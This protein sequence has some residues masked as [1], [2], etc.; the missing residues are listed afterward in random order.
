M[1]WNIFQWRSLKTRVTLFTLAIFLIGIWALALYASRML[2]EDM[3]RLLGEQ[4]F[5]VVSFMATEINHELD[6]RLRALETIA[7]SVSPAL[8][9]NMAALQVLLEQRPV[10]QSLFNGGVTALGLDGTAI[11]DVPLSAGRIGV[12]Y[13]DVDVTASALRE[14]KSTISRPIMGKKLRAPVFVMAVPIRDTR[15]KVIGALAGVTDLGKPNFLDKITENSYGKT[16]GYLLVAQQHRLI[17]TATDKSRIMEAL[18]APGTN[19]SMDRFMQG[20]EGYALMLNP[21][22]VEMLAAAKGVPVAGWYVVAVLHTAEAF[23]PIRALQQRMLLA[24]IFL[25]LLAGVLIWWML[26]RQLSPMLAAAI[27][28]ATV[29]DKGQFPHALPITSQDEIGALIGGFN[30]LLKTLAQREE[31]LKQSEERFRSLTELSSDWY[32]EQDRDLR[33]SFH[34]IGF[35]QRSGTTSDKLLGKCRWEEPGRVPLR[36]TW[37]EH[38]AMLEAHWPFQDFEYV[39]IG[40]DGEQYFLSISGAPI[41]DAAGNFNGYRGVGRNITER[42]QAQATLHESEERYRTLVE[43]TPEAIAVHRGG[44]LVYVNPAAIKMLGAKSAQDLIGKPFLDF[45]HPDFH[46]MTLARQKNIVDHAISVPLAEVRYLKL[47]GTAIDVEVQGTLIAYDGAPAIHTSI[48]DITERKRNEVARAS[49]EAQLREAQKM[50]AIGTLAGGIAHDFNNIIATILGNVELAREDVSANPLALRSLEEI[51]KAG[52]R[53]RD[54]VQQILSFSRRQP[55]ERKPTA[56]AP[57]VEESVRLL[58]ATLPA[59]LALEVHCDAAVPAVLADATQI[60]Q[61]LINLATNAMQ[62]MHGGPG[63]IGIR[64]DTVMLD[65]AWADAHPALRAMHARRP[66]RTVRLAVSDDG[67]GMDAATLGRIFEPFFTTKAVD[68]GTGLGLSVVH[69]IVQ[70]HE[71]AIVVDSQ[72]GKG[73]I[74]TLYLPAA[75][76]PAGA[77]E[78]DESAAATA[79]PPDMSGGRHILYIDDDDS[80]V[81]LVQ[82]LLERRGY[83][84]SG[85]VDQGEALDALRADPAG[86]DLVVTDYNMPGMSGLDVARAVRTIRADLPVAVASGFIDEELRA[87]AGGVGVRELIFKADA[88]EDFCVVVQRL[89]Q[90]V[91][92]KSKFS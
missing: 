81:L 62:T 17:V 70:G 43:W 13:M 25:T 42:K 89:A 34:S 38:R 18:P 79:A 21:L 82:R 33:L 51:R 78:L 73:A 66:G 30:R 3:Q 32:W 52:A 68:E 10:L 85:Y 5:S 55:T 90:T 2:R 19:P 22:G 8:L 53:A 58:R 24:T 77:P 63:R 26:R 41:Y 50:Q 83:R 87:Q 39:R 31:T 29:S 65:A 49:L 46:Q 71:G 59:R 67:P 61:I 37:D 6:D 7:G 35:A 56:L 60:K 88:V 27:T 86:F 48:R 15:G 72:P 47:D 9:S 75:E 84:V 91:A 80:L 12:N 74:F 76:E 69:G 44:K 23:A 14:G 40:D 28:L 1:N 92:E 45:V 11:A 4:Q 20:Y 64:L 57:V 54:L 16:G 36:G